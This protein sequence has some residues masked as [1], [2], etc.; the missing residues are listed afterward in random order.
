MQ[1]FEFQF[2]PKKRDR[3]V[4]TLSY[5]P[6]KGNRSLYLIGEIRNIIPSNEKLLKRIIKMVRDEYESQS[7]ESVEDALKNS[8]IKVNEYLSVEI[9]RDNVSWLGN[10][11]LAALSV[12]GSKVNIA[13]IG[14]IS[15][16]LVGFEKINEL[17]DKIEDRTSSNDFKPKTFGTIISGKLGR[18]E[19]IA[20]L[21]EE[22]MDVF[23]KSSILKKISELP[24]L[25]KK[26]IE[27]LVDS[28]KKEISKISGSFFLLDTKGPP[29]EKRSFLS[30]NEVIFSLKE[31]IIPIK[32]LI[33]K[34]TCILKLPKIKMRDEYRKGLVLLLLMVILLIS[35]FLIF[36]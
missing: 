28:Q 24:F 36:H 22:A 18:G 9:A 20:I 26:I 14:K 31:I 16:L 27:D 4:E 32:E 21:T 17:N 8:L 3:K 1:I 13:K 10:L 7:S 29:K 19:R 23:K 12:S 11:H 15:A 35:G 5:E 2:N 33:Q 25:D 34:T 30:E 6:E